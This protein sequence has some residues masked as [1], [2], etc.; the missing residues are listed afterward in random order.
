MS[1]PAKAR[2]YFK[3]EEISAQYINVGWFVTE[4]GLTDTM[5]ILDYPEEWDKLIMYEYEYT[6]EEVVKRVKKL[7]DKK[8]DY[9]DFLLGDDKD[10]WEI[11]VPLISKGDELFIED[12]DLFI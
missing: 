6:P 8:P 12:E 9:V 5:V 4:S 1:L 11:E 3:G 7:M 10:R 2:F